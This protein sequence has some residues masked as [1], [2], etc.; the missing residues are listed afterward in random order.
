MYTKKKLKI[1]EIAAIN[2]S[3]VYFL[4]NAK[5]PCKPNNRDWIIRHWSIVNIYETR[6]LNTYKLC[7]KLIL[8]SAFYIFQLYF[9]VEFWYTLEKTGF[10]S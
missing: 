8:I 2:L 10:K 7:Y 6:S 3:K 1:F 9:N 4:K 5:K